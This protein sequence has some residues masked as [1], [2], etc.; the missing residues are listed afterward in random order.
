MKCGECQNVSCAETVVT[1]R[2]LDA[3]RSPPRRWPAILLRFLLNQCKK[4]SQFKTQCKGK[5]SHA[6]ETA[7]ITVF[8]PTVCKHSLHFWSRIF[9]SRIFRAPSRSVH[10]VFCISD[11]VICCTPGWFTEH[12]QTYIQLLTGYTVS[13]YLGSF[14]SS[15][16]ILI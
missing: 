4:T 9:R 15:A 3:P 14:Y 10:A 16:Q 11:F 5:I 8:Y 12:T 2:E 1:Q 6:F 7:K 13:R